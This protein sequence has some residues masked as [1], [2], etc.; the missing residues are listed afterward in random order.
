MFK[1]ILAIMLICLSLTGC[2]NGS[3]LRGTSQSNVNKAG[4][5][6]VSSQVSKSGIGTASR[7]KVTEL[8]TKISKLNT[9]RIPVLMFHSINY[10]PKFPSNI[11]RVPEANFTAE[12]KWLFDNKYQTL[13]MD[14]LYYD[15]SKNISFPAK[16]VVLTFDDGYQDN[17]TGALPV[18]EK[19]HLQG[20]VF[21]ITGDINNTKN[22]YL[23]AAELKVMDKNGMNIEV[24]TVT[25][26]HLSALSSNVQYHEL[27]DSKATLEALLGRKVYYIAYPYGDYN[28]T[29]VSLVKQIG[30]RFGFLEDGGTGTLTSNHYEFPRV[31][32][33]RD[34]SQFISAVKD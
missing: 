6:K 33:G 26:R 11:L 12:M 2:D 25:H 7:S 8:S 10:D 13:S 9:K 28:A 23:S 31:F 14:T 4:I 22:G 24:H 27:N 21:M 32:V 20:T 1:R 16:S 18:M 19:Y 30:Y 15:I 5:A 17:Y 29:T 3:G 34:L